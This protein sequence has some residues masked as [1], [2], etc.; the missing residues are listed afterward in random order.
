[1]EGTWKIIIWLKD[2]SYPVIDDTEVL[3]YLNA[4]N[5]YFEHFIDSNSELVDTLFE[6]FKGRV[7]EEENHYLT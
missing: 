3:D 5:R 7:E 2:Q 4:E 6:E 1:M